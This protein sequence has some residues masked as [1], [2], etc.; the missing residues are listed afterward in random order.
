MRPRFGFHT[1]PTEQDWA[2]WGLDTSPLT[3]TPF[4]TVSY[5]RS[6]QRH[7][8]TNLRCA[9]VK[10]HHGKEVTTQQVTFLGERL[11]ASCKPDLPADVSSLLAV[12]R[13]MG[14]L[15]YIRR[16]L[17]PDWPSIVR[18]EYEMRVNLPVSASGVAN[19]AATDA[20]V[21]A[22]VATYHAAVAQLTDDIAQLKL[23]APDTHADA[24]VARLAQLFQDNRPAWQSA[25]KMEETF[26]VGYQSGN[27][28]L[29]LVARAWHSDQERDLAQA[30]IDAYREVAVVTIR[31]LP[32][33][34][35]T[36]L[37]D[38]ATVEEWAHAEFDAMVP[39]LVA[40]WGT[41]LRTLLTEI[42]SA[43]D[44][45]GLVMYD[46]P[47][48]YRTPD[49]YAHLSQ[50]PVIAEATWITRTP[51][52][53]CAVLEVPRTVAEDA[54][55]T[56]RFQEVSIVGQSGRDRYV[57]PAEFDSLASA[58]DAELRKHTVVSAQKDENP[59]KHVLE[60]RAR[61]REHCWPAREWSLRPTD[62]PAL[63]SSTL[64]D[65]TSR[66]SSCHTIVVLPDG[67]SDELKV[68]GYRATV[69]ADHRALVTSD[70]IEIPVS[71]IVGLDLYTR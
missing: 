30:V 7:S 32:T 5:G 51:D 4:T 47:M 21:A 25:S 67:S 11:C 63:T 41:V 61:R 8:H 65:L 37:T 6:K 2:R 48:D 9:E 12:A 26:N 27:R 40:D 71:S 29:E 45:V 13:A 64:R 23:Q 14:A 57:E 44:T 36:S 33:T 38:S 19:I 55:H 50:Y 52:A 20:R 24:K 46:W 59:K 34:P 54:V 3:S 56:A 69:S 53:K 60:A 17:R 15:D 18:A 1:E 58:A 31:H 66:L 10:A 39:G 16:F 42:E 43:T 49:R 68:H 22:S 62:G 28:L 35:T 70:G